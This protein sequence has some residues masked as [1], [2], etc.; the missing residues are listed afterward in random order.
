MT[1]HTEPNALKSIHALAA[2]QRYRV[3]RDGEGWPMIPGR[4]GQIE[5]HDG[6]DLAVYSDR[7]RLFAKLWA[8]PG[9]RRW[10]VGDQE[11]RALFPVEALDRVAAVIQA[12][13]R[14]SAASAGH[15]QKVA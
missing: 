12:R 6:R 5:Y 11:V 3:R 15:L 9:V 1:P 7:P 2:P 10:Q 8:I 13:Q 4:L 14:R